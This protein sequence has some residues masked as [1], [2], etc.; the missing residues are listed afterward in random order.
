ML[1][2][3]DISWDVHWDWING[4][5]G[6]IMGISWNLHNGWLWDSPIVR[7]FISVWHGTPVHFKGFCSRCLGY[8]GWHEMSPVETRK[9]PACRGKYRTSGVQTMT[10]SWAEHNDSH[11]AIMWQT[12][13]CSRPPRTSHMFFP[14]LIWTLKELRQLSLLPG[15][16]SN[17]QWCGCSKHG[18]ISPSS[19]AESC[20]FC[21]YLQGRPRWVDRLTDSEDFFRLWMWMKDLKYIQYIYIYTLCS[22][23]GICTNSCPNKSPKCR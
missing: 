6:W 21:L 8:W 17:L 10:C 11:A 16:G 1:W 2:H 3:R 12:Q 5:N 19:C 14:Y 20:S 9:P 22:M 15:S 4:I 18:E 23:Y 13:N 7:C